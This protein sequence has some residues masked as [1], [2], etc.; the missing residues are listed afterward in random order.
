MR[1]RLKALALITV[2]V[3]ALMTRMV[4][5]YHAHSNL[6]SVHQ[7][8]SECESSGGESDCPGLQLIALKLKRRIHLDELTKSVRVV[9]CVPVL[10]A[11]I[12]ITTSVLAALRPA[13]PLLDGTT[14]P[15]C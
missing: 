11:P 5:T 1:G 7:E 9:S 13:S 4:A 15:P 8:H 6:F 3:M 12:L 10:P 2:F 14:R